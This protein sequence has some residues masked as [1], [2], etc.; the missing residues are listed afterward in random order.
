MKALFLAGGF[1][2][3]VLCSLAGLLA[4]RAPDLI[5]RDAAIGCLAGALLVRWFWR[6]LLRGFQE[7]LTLR[8]QMAAEAAA[9]QESA[10]S[11]KNGQPQKSASVA[12]PPAPAS[13]PRSLPLTQPKTATR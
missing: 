7:T 8:R 13:P 3:F 6:V 4:G 5:L 1:A 12:S 10:R 2:G 11:A 9:A